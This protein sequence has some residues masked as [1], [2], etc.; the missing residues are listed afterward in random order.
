MGD[1]H[2]NHHLVD[3][4]YDDNNNFVCGRAVIIIAYTHATK[5]EMWEMQKVKNNGVIVAS[6]RR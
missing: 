5:E 1:D 6:K 2:N 4:V 3:D